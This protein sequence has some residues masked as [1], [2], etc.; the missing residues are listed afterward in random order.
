MIFSRALIHWAGK[1]A[2]A[3]WMI[4]YLVLSLLVVSVSGC[5]VAG[6]AAYI[7]MG[8]APVNPQYKLQHVPT[9]VFVENYSHPDSTEDADVLSRYIIED[10]KKN[11]NPKKGKDNDTN[12]PPIKFID[13]MAIYDLRTA[14]EARFHEMKIQEIGRDVHAEQVIY[15]TFDSLGV[16]S[17]GAN[18]MMH[19]MGSVRVKVVS[20]KTG[21]TL[22]PQESGGGYPVSYESKLMTPQQQL[23]FDEER[24]FTLRKMA[25][26][27][28]RLF[29]KWNPAD[30]PDE[31]QQM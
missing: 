4:A 31:N 9:L 12:V 18:E 1:Y 15:I 29:Y 23:T 10:L 6:V 30:E 20:C 19:G 11:L 17:V 21:Q 26:N 8:D 24:D 16:E 3:A 28:A 14:D 2:T 5:A 13:P 25:H 27:I 22:W 7:L